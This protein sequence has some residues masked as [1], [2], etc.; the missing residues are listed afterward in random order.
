MTGYLCDTHVV[1]W[2]ASAPERLRPEIQN[3]L[4][5]TAERVL[6]SSVTVAEMAIKAGLG[7][8]DLPVDPV[9]LCRSLGFGELALAWHQAGLVASL[10][11][12]HRDPFDRLLLAQALAE[13][14][15]LITSDRTVASYPEVRI[16]LA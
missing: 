7:K 16:E 13:D 9:E 8:L 15:V 2:A 1:L 12:I 6:I 10:P 3:I 11:P 14:L 5:D 4:S